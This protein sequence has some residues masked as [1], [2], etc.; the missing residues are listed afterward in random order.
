MAQL[1]VDYVIA[2]VQDKGQSNHGEKKVG[3]ANL[4][5]KE[6][7]NREER[8]Q[9]EEIKKEADVDK[10]RLGKEVKKVDMKRMEMEKEATDEVERKRVEAGKA[11][12]VQTIK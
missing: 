8:K 2:V 9:G 11:V 6:E 1:F 4:K 5:L 12:D 7:A 10:V 3:G